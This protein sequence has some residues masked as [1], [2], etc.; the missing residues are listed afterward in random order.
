M[1]SLPWKIE[2]SE[3]SSNYD[4][5]KRRFDQLIKT[6]KHNMCLYKD[7]YRLIQDY[8]KQGIV[9]KVENG[10]NARATYYMP[11]RAVIKEER[12]TTRLR[13]VFDASSR[14][15]GCI[16]LNYCLFPGPNLNPD[17]LS[18]LLKYPIAFMSDISKAFLQTTYLRLI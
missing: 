1:V 9:E 16:S 14:M 7:Y 12:V 3:L 8:V 2:K 17:L 18:V 6:F 15:P 4:V 10:Q 13:V 11:H 5:A